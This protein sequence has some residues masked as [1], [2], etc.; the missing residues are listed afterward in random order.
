[1]GEKDAAQLGAT[2][3]VGEKAVDALEDALDRINSARHWGL[4]DIFGG[5]LL[6]TAFKNKRIRETEDAL[7]QADHLLDQFADMALDYDISIAEH[8]DISEVLTVFDYVMDNFVTDLMIQSKL[9]E[10]RSSIQR[11]LDEV[12]QALDD[13]HGRAEEA[14]RGR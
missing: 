2:I 7:T 3:E 12:C 8:P 1:M 6:V 10:A 11:T 9:N 13:L 5:R 14:V 4:A